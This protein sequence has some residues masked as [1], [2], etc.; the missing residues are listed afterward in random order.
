MKALFVELCR[1]SCLVKAL[2]WGRL[3]L[4]LLVLGEEV[5]LSCLFLKPLLNFDSLLDGCSPAIVF[6]G[7]MISRHVLK[8][9]MCHLGRMEMV[10]LL[11][12]TEFS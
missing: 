2:K 3:N 9:G 5:V 7:V 4:G 12:L 6:L 1:C 8:I 10:S 11:S